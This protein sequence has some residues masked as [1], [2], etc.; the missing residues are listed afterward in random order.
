MKTKDITVTITLPTSAD[1]I[2]HAWIDSKTHSEIIG[3]TAVIDPKVGGKFSLWDNAIIGKTIE[4]NPKEHKIIQEWRDNSSDWTDNY[5]S[6]VTITI[7]T[8]DKTHVTLSIH[9][10]GIPEEHID[11]IKEGWE[12]YYAEPF[13]KYFAS[14]Q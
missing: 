3:D 9:H 8:K 14:K 13:K 1:Q 11:D 12:K 10:K 6:T 4:L 2:Y 5:F 7:E